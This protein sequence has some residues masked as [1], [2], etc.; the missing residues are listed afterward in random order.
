M[1]LGF[2]SHILV[3]RKT[4]KQNTSVQTNGGKYTEALVDDT[5]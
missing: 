1:W 3:V 5:T 2:P 4:L